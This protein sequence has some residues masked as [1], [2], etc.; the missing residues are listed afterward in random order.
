M[1]EANN[2]VYDSIKRKCEKEGLIEI[3]ARDELEA[4]LLSDSKLCDWLDIKLETWNG[5]KRPSEKLAKHLDDKKRI[6]YPRDYDRILPY[7]AA[8]GINES[9]QDALKTLKTLPC[10]SA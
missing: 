7:L 4:W 6:V 9:F 1:V 2:K 3:V 10:T 8:D 5:K